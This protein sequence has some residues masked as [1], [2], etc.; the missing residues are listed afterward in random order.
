MTPLTRQQEKCNLK[1][2]K[3]PTTTAPEYVGD[4]NNGFPHRQ[5]WH[6]NTP[7][8][9]CTPKYSEILNDVRE[10]ERYSVDIIISALT[11][12]WTRF[13]PQKRQNFLNR[14]FAFCFKGKLLKTTVIPKIQLL[15][16]DFL[17]QT[18]PPR[19]VRF[20]EP[21]SGIFLPEGGRGRWLPTFYALSR[22]LS[23]GF[24]MLCHL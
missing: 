5:S 23:R 3:T 21:P 18:F 19:R 4:T 10:D 12:C 9:F 24:Y 6:F 7:L 14:L 20:N 8:G 1:P 15:H 11:H 16:P 13:R 2:L 22:I 17:F